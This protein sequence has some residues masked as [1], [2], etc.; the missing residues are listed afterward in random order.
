MALGPPVDE[1]YAKSCDGVLQDVQLPGASTPPCFEAEYGDL[2][3]RREA[4][5]PSFTVVDPI[6]IRRYQVPELQECLAGRQ[7]RLAATKR[8]KAALG[9]RDTERS[10]PTRPHPVSLADRRAT[11]KADNSLADLINAAGRSVLDDS[12]EDTNEPL[13][14]RHWDSD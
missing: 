8:K 2:Y 9:L 5:I 13:R 14:H 3:S 10:V 12:H 1:L 7:R 4:A 11:D 6:H